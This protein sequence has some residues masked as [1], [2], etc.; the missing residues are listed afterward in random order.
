M[1][2]AKIMADFNNYQMGGYQQYP[3]IPGT[4]EAWNPGFVPNP[5]AS[6][7]YNNIP[8]YGA[9]YNGAFIPNNNITIPHWTNVLNNEMIKQLQNNPQKNLFDINIDENELYRAWCYHN[10]NVKPI[11]IQ[12]KDGECYCP[13]C[14]AKFR[15]DA[16]TEDE[17]KGAIKTLTDILQQIKLSGQIPTGFGKDFFSIIPLIN[18]VPEIYSYSLKNLEKIFTNT[19]YTSASDVSANVLYNNLNGIRNTGGIFPQQQMGY[20]NMMQQQYQQQPIGN[21]Y[22]NGYQQPLQQPMMANNVNP[23]QI[24]YGYNQQAPNPQFN[25]Q[26]QFMMGGQQPPVQQQ[27]VP[28]NT[29]NSA[30]NNVGQQQQS[31]NSTTE[32]GQL[33]L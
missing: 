27:Q 12:T 28:T 21:Y 33:V 3:T 8:N 20:P 23:M 26:N 19:M 11:V 14:Q 10:D 1:K 31:T 5:F 13:I 9:Y 16:Y 18:K 2:E 30:P 32:T 4:P 15:H 22:N 17:V 29:Q 25:M 6:N 7:G 24:P